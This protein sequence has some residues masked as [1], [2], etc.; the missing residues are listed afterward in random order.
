MIEA[1][2]QA[3]SF[4][5][6]Y[7]R[8]G[9][10]GTVLLLLA[11]EDQELGDWLFATLGE[12]FRTIAPDLPPADLEATPSLLGAW[13][14]ALIDG[15]GLEEPAVVAGL[16]H[17]HALLPFAARD[18]DRVGRLVLLQGDEDGNA[19][20]TE[21]ALAA[22]VQAARRP[23]RVVAVPRAEDHAGRTVALAGILDFLSMP[24]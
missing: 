12:R 16:A 23:V 15:L 20:E 18:P 7:R 11:G 22:E 10:G 3:G 9:R 1:V 13:L 17:A 5:T 8:A 4:E 24:A 21:A 14:C 2:V 6:A 19:A